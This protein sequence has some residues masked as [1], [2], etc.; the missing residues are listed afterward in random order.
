LRN[1]GKIVLA[2]LAC[3]LPVVASCKA[4]PFTVNLPSGYNGPVTISCDATGVS[5]AS[6]AV[7]AHGMAEAKVC[8]TRPTDLVVMRD[9][10]HIDTFTT[11]DW[12]TTGDNIPVGIRFTVR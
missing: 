2:L 10:K 11:P 6:I 1:P 9:G 5:A 3:L 8:P 12:E 7:D 4:P